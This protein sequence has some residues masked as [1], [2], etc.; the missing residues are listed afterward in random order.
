MVSRAGKYEKEKNQEAKPKNPAQLRELALSQ[1]SKRIGASENWTEQSRNAFVH[2]QVP[3]Y[4]SF[5]MAFEKRMGEL[6][7]IV[8]ATI[9]SC[10]C[11]EQPC[12][13]HIGRSVLIRGGI[14]E[15]TNTLTNWYM[16]FFQQSTSIKAL[17]IEKQVELGMAGYKTATVPVWTPFGKEE[18]APEADK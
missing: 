12:K 16:N 7:D 4:T 5:G 14:F 10:T 9:T 18:D 8:N 2:H 15:N 11:E 6:V 17:A 3:V 13:T 1:I